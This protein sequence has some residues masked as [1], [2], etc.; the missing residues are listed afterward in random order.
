[1]I[2]PETIEALI[3]STTEKV[4]PSIPFVEISCMEIQK[5]ASFQN[6]EDVDFFCF[7]DEV[8][9]LFPLVPVSNK[10]QKTDTDH[11]SALDKVIGNNHAKFLGKSYSEKIYSSHV[12][13]VFVL[14]EIGMY[15]IGRPIFKQ[16]SKQK[17]D[18]F[19]EENDEAILFNISTDKIFKS[20]NDI[21]DLCP[22]TAIPYEDFK[23]HMRVKFGGDKLCIFCFGQKQPISS[24]AESLIELSSSNGV[25]EIALGYE[26]NIPGYYLSSAY[27]QSYSRFQYSNWL[28]NV[29]TNTL[30]TDQEICSVQIRNSFRICAYN[31][32]QHEKK[33]LNFQIKRTAGT[34]HM[35]SSLQY[36]Y[37]SIVS[38]L[39]SFS[40]ITELINNCGLRFEVYFKINS[41]D[42]FLNAKSVIKKIPIWLKLVYISN[43]ILATYIRG[44]TQNLNDVF[45]IAIRTSSSSWEFLFFYLYGLF[46]SSIQSTQ[47]MTKA[48][49]EN[50]VGYG[51]PG[52]SINHNDGSLTVDFFKFVSG[53]R[54]WEILVNVFGTANNTFD[55]RLMYSLKIYWASPLLLGE[56]YS[57]HFVTKIKRFFLIH[58]AKCRANQERPKKMVP[59]TVFMETFKSKY[60]RSKT[61]QNII[62]DVLRFS[63][64]FYNV[65]LKICSSLVDYRV[66]FFHD[67]CFFFVKSSTE[68]ECFPFFSIETIQDYVQKNSYFELSKIFDQNVT[69]DC[70]FI[71][72][73]MTLDTITKEFGKYF[74]SFL[75]KNEISIPQIS[76]DADFF[77][78]LL[79]TKIPSEAHGT[80]YSEFENIVDLFKTIEDFF[81]FVSFGA[82]MAYYPNCMTYKLRHRRD[83]FYSNLLPTSCGVVWTFNKLFHA[84]GLFS[85]MRTHPNETEILLPIP[86]KV[87]L[88]KI[89]PFEKRKHL[90][91][92][93]RKV[94]SLLSDKMEDKFERFRRS[95]KRYVEYQSIP[96]EN[97]L[98]KRA[99]KELNSNDSDDLLNE[100]HSFDNILK[101]TIPELVSYQTEVALNIGKN[102]SQNTFG[103]NKSKQDDEVSHI[104]KEGSETVMHVK[105][106]NEIQQNNSQQDTYDDDYTDESSSFIEETQSTDNSRSNG[107]SVFD[108]Y[109]N[110]E[111]LIKD[112]INSNLVLSN[113]KEILLDSFLTLDDFHDSNQKNMV[114]FFTKSCKL[115]DKNAL[116]IF[117]I[118]K[119]QLARCSSSLKK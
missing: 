52:S 3:S 64:R 98:G 7:T 10:I 115:S 57:Q 24:I 48:F 59:P 16:I 15:K 109:E 14:A 62:N 117:Q 118:F 77:L 47:K 23:N 60:S 33:H 110:Q 40:N 69:N 89:L 12:S 78:R 97:M 116:K 55:I 67:T 113:H 9:D 44:V 85:A 26:F 61:I 25:L 94:Y 71:D 56:E 30:I 102:Q 28:S 51:I 2:A 34:E 41:C 54:L 66:Y 70:Q 76:A 107:Q 19:E 27:M 86:K 32:L 18:D 63:T 53:P 112:A 103:L 72:N 22:S 58:A 119:L 106:V 101:N 29:C 104:P 46:V 38:N 74:K 84:S 21:L 36:Y 35:E 43:S 17:N 11:R 93:C 5:I 73:L 82:I 20:I 81:Y 6:E 108:E 1:M 95:A 83:G 105:L 79:F 39:K 42:S 65:F 45:Q 114:E 49:L 90:L 99:V 4:N 68:N 100:H 80:Y 88:G 50:N 87:K 91:G 13:S 96:N 92:Q 75:E 37:Q 111:D 8:K 31:T